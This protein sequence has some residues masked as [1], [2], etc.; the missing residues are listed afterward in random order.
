MKFRHNLVQYMLVDIC[1]R[2][3]ISIRK[4][5]PVGF[6][7]ETGKDLR[8]VDLLLFNWLQGKDACVDVTRGSPFVGAGVFS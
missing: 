3:G 7:S 5:A 6:S 4:E 1:C 2:V 8:P